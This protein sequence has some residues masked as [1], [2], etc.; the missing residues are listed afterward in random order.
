MDE[1]V[2]YQ[3]LKKE[4]PSFSESRLRATAKQIADNPQILESGMLGGII[5][6]AAATKIGQR[7]AATRA[8]KGVKTVTGLAKTAKK[9]TGK[10]VLFGGGA[11]GIAGLAFTGDGDSGTPDV[12]AQAN[13]D[14]MFQAAQYEASRWRHQ[15]PC[16]N[17]SRTATI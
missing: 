14:L 12:T 2:I 10:Q 8:G 5:S 7:F 9:P 15:C 11:L 4:N 6:K 13:A 1:K 17:C 16:S 3:I